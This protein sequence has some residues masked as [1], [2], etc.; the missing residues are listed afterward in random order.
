M[1]ALT[2]S[3]AIELVGVSKRFPLAFGLRRREVLHSIDLAVER[4]ARLAL[5]G[6]NGS[7]KTTLLRLLAGIE[8]PSAG[9]L[10]VL[11]GD[12]RT[13]ATRKQLAFLPEDSPFPGELSARS[14]LDLLGSFAGMPR[15]ERA[16]RGA[17]LLLRVGLER[18]GRTP[19]KRYSRGMLRRFALAQAFLTRPELV[20]LDEPTA[21]LDAQGF[22][23]AEDLLREASARGTTIVLASHVVQDVHEHCRTLAVLVDGRLVEHG[24]V[25][26]LLSDE[27][28]TC[29]E[30]DGLD[31]H[32]R[33]ELESWVRTHG[34]SV[35]R[36]ASTR[37]LLDLYRRSA[38]KAG[39]E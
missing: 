30:V 20:L 9:S 18:A 12:P 1:T 6:P 39:G 19:L 24:S 15:R 5:V 26:A 21:G 8:R 25:E 32:A 16:S 13:R 11:G 23:V 7:G 34:G 38:G 36:A 35:R 2:G 28:G 4:G 37:G 33:A 22:G 14:V 17:E 27:G 3:L 29:M 31:E 10:T